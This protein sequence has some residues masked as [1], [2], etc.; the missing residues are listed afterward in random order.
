MISSAHAN[1]GSYYERAMFRLRRN[2]RAGA[3][4]DLQEA[5]RLDGTWTVPRTALRSLSEPG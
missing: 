2:D 3:V 5:V 4:E 1:A